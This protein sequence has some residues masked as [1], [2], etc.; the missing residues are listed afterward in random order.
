MAGAIGTSHNVVS[1]RLR[2]S[3]T[4]A[5]TITS[6]SSV[7]GPQTSADDGD[8]DADRRAVTDGEARTHDDRTG[9][10]I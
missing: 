8:S 6:T 3:S 5:I 2:H 9:D 10:R 1:I 7:T 4:R